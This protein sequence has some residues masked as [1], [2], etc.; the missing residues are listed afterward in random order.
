MK[1]NL[2]N[3]VLFGVLIFFSLSMRAMIE[4]PMLIKQSV[5]LETKKPSVQTLLQDFSL[6]NESEM[7][8][9]KNFQES[10]Q[11]LKDTISKY[12]LLNTMAMP[13]FKMFEKKIF[14]PCL[15]FIKNV[16]VLHNNTIGVIAA[17]PDD[18]LSYSEKEV[19]I[20]KLYKLIKDQNETSATNRPFSFDVAMQQYG[21]I[22][23]QCYFA[24]KEKY[25]YNQA[26]A[27][28][29]EKIQ[30]RAAYFLHMF[31][32]S[33]TCDQIKQCE[34]LMNKFDYI[35]RFRSFIEI[36]TMTGMAYLV[37]WGINN[38]DWY[39]F[40][41]C[42]RNNYLSSVRHAITNNNLAPI[43][44]HY[45]DSQCLLEAAKYGHFDIV[46]YLLM[47][48]SVEISAKNY[49]TVMHAIKNK[50]KEMIQFLFWHLMQ[51]GRFDAM[52]QAL[53]KKLFN[54]LHNNK[55]TQ[56]DVEE[57]V[58]GYLMLGV[59]TKPIEN[60]T[61]KSDNKKLYR[62]YVNTLKYGC[63]YNDPLAI[64]LANRK[65]CQMLPDVYDINTII[66]INESLL[67][68]ATRHNSSDAAKILL[69]LGYKPNHVSNNMTPIQLAQKKSYGSLVDVLLTSDTINLSNTFGCEN[70][71]EVIKV[72]SKVQNHNDKNVKLQRIKYIC[73]LIKHKHNIKPLLE[74]LTIFERKEKF[75]QRIAQN[76]VSFIS[77]DDL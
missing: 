22:L 28:V 25:E 23:E 61:K 66:H 53:Y 26:F 6:I 5:E 34:V 63:L 44:V 2:K 13:L 32:D 52:V 12:K 27:L 75:D 64:L 17:V 19:I 39:Y 54:E 46:K 49:E 14:F 58:L 35:T 31:K 70:R 76:I 45:N 72:L 4:K 3:R 60:F 15:N 21:Q 41:Y 30:R 69:L 57:A 62:S 42:C 65:L 29:G 1:N 18:G 33:W 38:S 51:S 16:D 7:K 37:Y 59:N 56:E 43:P 48:T 50:H 36:A 74:K 11:S 24:F 77:K 40:L 55:V 73:N 8:D 67:H 47:N 68:F 9:I 10:L 20:K 71:L